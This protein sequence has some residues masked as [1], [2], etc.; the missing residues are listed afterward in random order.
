[1]SDLEKEIAIYYNKYRN[2]VFKYDSTDYEDNKYFDEVQYYSK[3][4]RRLF[5][6]NPQHYRQF[7]NE[8]NKLDRWL[9][10]DINN[11]K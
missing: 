2:A 3:I 8:T 4:L 10:E 6:K 1:M 5:K 9:I 7:V 11:E